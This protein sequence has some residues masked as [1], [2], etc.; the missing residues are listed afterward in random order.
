MTAMLET[1]YE[2]PEVLDFQEV[3][4][5]TSQDHENAEAF[6]ESRARRADSTRDVFQCPPGQ[7][8]QLAGVHAF[9]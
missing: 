2:L 3:E 1:K 5:P 4:K 7:R 8:A 6:A 9:I